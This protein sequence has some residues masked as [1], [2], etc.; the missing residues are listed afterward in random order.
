MNVKIKEVL[1]L[2]GFWPTRANPISGIFVEQQVQAYLECGLSVKVFAPQARRGIRLQ[3]EIYHV[4]GAMEVASPVVNTVPG[5]WA[6]H[7]LCW[8]WNTY[9]C[10]KKINT[11]RE[12]D[13]WQVAD[14]I[15]L[16]GIRPM[17]LAAAMSERLGSVPL[18]CT[19]H[20]IDAPLASAYLAHSHVRESLAM[21]WNRCS[22][23]VLVGNSIRSYASS[24]GVPQEKI[25]VVYNGTLLLQG[26]EAIDL[27]RTTVR[28]G[29][30]SNL[31]ALKGIDINIRALSKIREKRPDLRWSYDIVGDGAE[32]SRLEK[33]V[34]DLNLVDLV[35]FHGR[36]SYHEAMHLLDGWDVFS[37]P[38]WRE[39]FGIVYLEAIAR[40]KPIVGCRDWGAADVVGNSACGLLVA[41]KDVN[42]LE[43]ALL[44]LI[45]DADLRQRMSKSAL[46]RVRAFSWHKNA[47]KCLGLMSH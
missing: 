17:G 1:V 41:D 23:V 4:E 43:L 33:L 46:M 29:S 42:E 22:R 26:R 28:I 12:A 2:T 8:R 40:G 34:V 27:G 13:W 44:N 18:I 36:T 7:R 16:H 9:Q 38:S 10:L 25:E 14:A 37:L 5:R 3:R 32:R 35:K 11:I 39:A 15:H 30:I 21:L 31:Q 20:G 47:L 24:I 45:S 19:L 6:F